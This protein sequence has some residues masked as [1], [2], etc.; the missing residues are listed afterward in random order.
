MRYIIIISVIVFWALSASAQTS[1]PKNDSIQPPPRLETFRLPTAV[2]IDLKDVNNNINKF[3]EL[4]APVVGHERFARAFV[5]DLG[6]THPNEKLMVVL[7]STAFDRFNTE[8]IDGK[9]IKVRGR[10]TLYNNA[11]PELV[12]SRLD[13]IKIVK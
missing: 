13:D 7:T 8:G 2:A 3:V 1:S 6:G 9:T 12:V 4:Q 11:T 5:I 10:I